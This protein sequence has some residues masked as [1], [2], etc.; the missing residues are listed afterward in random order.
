MNEEIDETEFYH[1]DFTTASDWEIFVSRIEEIINLWKVEETNSELKDVHIWDTKSEKLMFVDTEFELLYFKK[2]NDKESN[3]NDT[4]DKSKINKCINL[5]YDFQLFDVNTTHEHSNL[6]VWYGLKEYFVLT[7]TGNYGVTSESKIKVLLSSLY[8]VVSNLNCEIPIFIQIKEKWQKCYLGVHECTKYRTSFEMIHLK[9]GPQHSQH[10]TGLLSL[11][12]S[13]IMSPI[14]LDHIIS[15]V[16]FTFDLTDFGKSSWKQDIFNMD[17]EVLDILSLYQMPFGVTMDPI[18]VLQLKATWFN[19]PSYR[20]NDS[21]AYSDFNA[22]H[23]DQWSILVKMTEQP[24]CLLSDCLT[25]YLHLYE[26]NSTAYD[27]LGELSPLE[28]IVESKVSS[29]PSILGRAARNSLSGG[30]KDTSAIPEEVLVPILYYLFPDAEQP[31]PKFPYDMG[32]EKTLLNTN[33]I[34]DIDKD[35]KGFKTCPPDSLLWRLAV[36]SASLQHS[37][38]GLRSSAQLWYEF[39]QEMRYR[40]DKNIIIPG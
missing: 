11:F 33:N 24:I 30:S 3:E 22:K 21:Q 26:N 2:L 31:E 5:D 27:V 13:K 38:G 8:I 29:L 10:L 1:Q 28:A 35:C 34:L 17:T 20:V 7:P 36:V 39:V 40:W 23:A 12:T 15:S 25:E 6:Y 19:I 4:T 9:R 32:N 18:S 16:Q 37:V 14:S